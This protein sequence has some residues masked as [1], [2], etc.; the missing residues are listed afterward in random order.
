MIIYDDPKRLGTLIRFHRSKA[1]L[2]QSELAKQARVKSTTVIHE[3]E[4]GLK[5]TIRL[6]TLTKI[7]KV[8]NIDLCFT[9][10]LMAKFETLE[11]NNESR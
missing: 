1:E 5:S 10:P 7:L 4:K 2:T 11:K 6:E 3:L 9:S 8:L